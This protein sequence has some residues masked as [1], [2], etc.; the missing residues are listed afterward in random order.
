MFEVALKI[1]QKQHLNV[2]TEIFVNQFISTID[3]GDDYRS[4]RFN[5]Q[6]FSKNTL[7]GG[8]EEP[9]VKKNTFSQISL[10][11]VAELNIFYNSVKHN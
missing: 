3:L 4:G 1:Q 2:E 5:Y 10:I 6:H 9:S 8:F 11:H 7:Y